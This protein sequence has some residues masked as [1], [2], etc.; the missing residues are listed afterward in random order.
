MNSENVV[1]ITLKQLIAK[2][3]RSKNCLKISQS[4][5]LE[6]LH[7]HHPNNIRMKTLQATHQ[8][9]SSYE[10]DEDYDEGMAGPEAGE[11]IQQL[12]TVYKSLLT[13]IDE[14]V[15]RQG[16]RKTPER[17]AKA[18]WYF[19]KGYR[20]NLAGQCQC[21]DFISLFVWKRQ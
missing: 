13:S 12:T 14:D 15:D 3:F 4:K 6:V 5:Q 7:N 19:T 1:E 20:Q 10:V 18:I 11:K 2:R 21:H 16:L 17:A 8:F 9:G